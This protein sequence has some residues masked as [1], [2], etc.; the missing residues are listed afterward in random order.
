MIGI[1]LIAHMRIAS[2]TKAAVES[3]LQPQTSFEA[4]DVV[5]SDDTDTQ[6]T[7]ITASLKKVARDCNSILVMTDVFGAT[8]CNMA[9]HMILQENIKADVELIAGFNLP[10]VIKAILERNHYNLADLAHLSLDAGQK[11]LRLGSQE[12]VMKQA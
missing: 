2:E 6:S 8:P 11:Y 9:I 3:I 4:V 5:N 1:I 10:C 7:L 12:T